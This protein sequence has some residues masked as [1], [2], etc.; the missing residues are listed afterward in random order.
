MNTQDALHKLVFEF[1]KLPSIGKK[2][3]QRLAYYIMSQ[4]E[5]NALELANSIIDAKRK[6]NFCENCFNYS[7]NASCRICNDSSRDT[8]IICVT[9][10]PREIDVI[11]STHE[12]SGTYHV[13]H[14]LIAPLKGISPENLKI[15]E[16]L[17]RIEKNEI[18]EII[19]ALDFTVEADATT[20]Y[21]T[22]LIKP[23]GVS[24]TRIASGIP[25][26]ASLEFADTVT[27]GQALRGRIKL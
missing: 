1:A 14:G 6:V 27:L 5:E 19:I 22:R 12:Y 26:G 21:L 4:S 24:I 3:A 20:L 2:T 8:G 25:A 11:E 7:E 10:T 16:L 13:L 17:N 18:R 9:E 15:R 23:L